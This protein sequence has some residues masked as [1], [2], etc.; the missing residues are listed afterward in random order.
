MKLRSVA[1]SCVLVCLVAG[2]AF[3]EKLKGVIWD[4]NPLVVE[5]VEIVIH[6][7]TKI[8]RKKHPNITAPELR[9]GWQ[10]EVE[11]EVEG[12]RLVAKKIKVISEEKTVT[13]TAGDELQFMGIEMVFSVPELLRKR[14]VLSVVRTIWR[15]WF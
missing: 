3:G 15:G 6:D 10:V 9:I 12:R 4:V 1:S 13:T 2:T 8:E 7:R 11:G 5:G 14:V